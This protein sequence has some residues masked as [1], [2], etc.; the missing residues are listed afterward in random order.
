MESRKRASM[1]SIAIA[2][3]ATTMAIILALAVLLDWE[4]SLGNQAFASQEEPTF[5]MTVTRHPDAVDSQPGP[6]AAK[7]L[8]SLLAPRIDTQVHTGEAVV[9]QIMLRYKGEPLLEDVDYQVTLANNVDVG[10]AYATVQGI[11][12]WSGSIVL[13]FKIANLMSA[14]DVSDIA[15][16]AHTGSPVC[17]RPAVRY[18]D[19]ELHEGV[20]YELSYRNNTKPGTALVTI[21]GRG[22]YVGVKVVSFRIV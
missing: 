6:S 8:Q 7:S 22:E 13:S 5:T 10:T 21:T 16:E 4:T 12:E 19:I 11:G 2:A 14:A 9:P 1:A 17:P 15:P 20:D 3:I 18:G